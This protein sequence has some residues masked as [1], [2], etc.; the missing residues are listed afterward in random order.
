VLQFLDSNRR[1]EAM[2]KL[3]AESP[4]DRLIAT[5]FRPIA[6]HPGAFGLADDA[7]AIAPP[8][9]CDLVLTTDGVIS[10]VH[11]F[12]DDPADRVARKALRINLS[13]LAAKGATPL[14]FLLSIGLPAGLPPD[15]LKSFARGLGEDAAHYRC[16]L[17]GGDTDR[18]PG[19]ITVNIAALGTVPHGTMVRRAGAREGDLVMVTGTIGDAA[20][21][22]ALRKDP[23]AAARWG[24]D[25]AMRE[26]LLSRYL[27]PQPRNAIAEALRRHADAA[28][29]VSD[30]LAG[31]LAKLARVSG[32]GAAVAVERVPLSAAARTVLAA[33]PQ[34]IETILT[35]G[36]DFEVAAAVPG[37]RVDDLRAEAADAGVALSEIGVVVTGRHEARFIAAD[38]KALAFKRPSYSHF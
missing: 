26:H 2:A 21:G 10:G 29:D 24:L 38:G 8:P 5:Y 13:D 31:D 33:E 20:L 18:S 14:G 11:F 37:D 12:P 15:W 7:A 28:L 27:L 17:L 30:G 19:A 23:A 9:G 6:T 25:E 1:Q 4:E 35:G 32:L 22:L 3:D 34:M 16:P 36:D